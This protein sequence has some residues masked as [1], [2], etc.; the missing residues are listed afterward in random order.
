MA[1][2]HP[3]RLIVG[4]G[5]PGRDYAATRHNVGFMVLD[6]IAADASVPFGTEKRW[7]AQIAKDAP[8]FLLKPQTFMND[9]GLAVGKVAGFYKIEPEE[10]LVIYDD[11]DLPLGRMRIREGG[12]AG[13]H[14][15][16]RSIIAHLGTDQFPRLRLGIGRRGEGAIGHVLGKFGEE[17]RSELEKCLK[18]AVLATALIAEEGISAAMTRFNSVGKPPKKKRVPKPPEGEGEPGQ[19]T[20]AAPERPADQN[21]TLNE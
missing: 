4:L 11:L 14:N 18:N 7:K 2:S 1:E 12:S 15:G 21:E 17:E 10:V 8:R 13:G 5:N 6:R 3:P 9:S 19:Q 20:E 16:M